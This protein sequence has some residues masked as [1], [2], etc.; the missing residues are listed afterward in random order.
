[1]KCKFAP[2]VVLCL[3]LAA[4]SHKVVVGAANQFD[5]NS[6]LT[7]VTADSVIQQTK[8]D[9][10][11]GTFPANIATTVKASLN[12]LIE[13]YDV[14]NPI[15]IAY[16]T[17]ALAGQATPAQQAAVTSSL[18]SVNSATTALITAKGAN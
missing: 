16:H 15:Y 14:A 17:A 8:A 6:Y 4:C 5:S 13:A 7:L 9:L 1:M 10:A 3:V 11:A 2:V 12:G 18:A